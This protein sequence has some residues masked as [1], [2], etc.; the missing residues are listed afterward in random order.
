HGFHC[1]H[2]AQGVGRAATNAFVHSF[3]LIL[4]LDLFLGIGLNNVQDYL[5]PE[6]PR[7]LL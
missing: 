1:D 6:G 4:V 3:V 2:G 5:R 7:S